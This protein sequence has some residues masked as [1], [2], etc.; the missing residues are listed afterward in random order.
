[1]IFEQIVPLP[2]VQNILLSSAYQR[3]TKILEKV[4]SRFYWPGYKRDV[5][6]IVASC[7][8]FQ[9]RNSPTKK[10]IHSLRAWKP[11]FPFSTVRNDFLGLLPPFAGN[12][13]ILLIGDH[14]TKWHEAIALTDQSAPTTTKPSWIIGSPALAVLRA[15]TPTNDVIWMLNFS[16]V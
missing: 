15:L 5:E 3:V 13:Y 11:S 6:V 2:L 1:M 12:Q 16:Q 4:H 8:V 9:K 14:L 7:F 10:H